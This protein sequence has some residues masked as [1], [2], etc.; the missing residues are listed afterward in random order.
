MEES[1]REASL[2][3]TPILNSNHPA[4]VR[5]ADALLAASPV[6]SRALLQAAH[7][8]LV[9]YLAP[10]YS[11]RE[12]QPA[13]I[14]LVRRRGSCSQR[15]A[16]LEAAARAVGIGTRSRALWIN[17]QFW[18]PRFT[19]LRSFLPRR[20]LIAWPE[21]LLDGEWVGFEEL[22]GPVQE[23]AE[24]AT[25]GFSNA[26]GE[27]LFEAVRRTAIDWHGQTRW[28]PSGTAC[29]L[30]GFV[31]ADDG[32]FASRDA[33]FDR[34]GLFLHQPG[35]CLFELIVSGHPAA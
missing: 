6:S 17:G 12:R 8:Q 24:R 35:G 31:V 23:L 19:R 16:V 29:D 14:T 25:S 5:F 1:K 21:F 2:Q 10:V 26:T 28:C 18:S 20:V 9:A 34:Y 27:T 13:A 33:V 3:P 7:H 15:M 11:L 30:S 22:Y 32:V 4:L